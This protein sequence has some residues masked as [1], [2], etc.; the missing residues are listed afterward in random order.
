MKKIFIILSRDPR[1]AQ[2][3]MFLINALLKKNYHIHLFYHRSKISNDAYGEL[4]FKNNN[5]ETHPFDVGSSNK[6]NFIV[7]TLEIIKKF[8]IIKPTHIIAVDKKT[9]FIV[10]FLNFFKKKFNKI[11]MILDFDYPKNESIKES[12]ITKIQFFFS[13]YVD[14]FLFPSTKRAKKFF[15][16]S[17]INDKNFTILSNHFPKNFKPEVS[18][19]LNQI[20][21]DKNIKYSKIVCSLGTIGH[22]H[23]FPELIRSVSQWEDGVILI[24]G[25]WPTK[26]AK[27]SLIKIISEKN[28]QKKVLILSD[29]SEKLWCEILLKS[30]LGICFYKQDSIS[31]QYMAGPSTKLSNYLLANIPFIACDNDDFRT[32][33]LKYNLCE[34][35]NPLEPI[36]ISNKINALINNKEKYNLLK[37]NSRIAFS[38]SL[39]FDV[40]F[41][42]L[43]EKLIILE[44]DY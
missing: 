40:Q 37:K 36:D 35:V 8:N 3:L 4:D 12:L 20:L 10:F 39:N 25:G 29:I 32:F 19:K 30:Y 17:T 28:L 24:I 2:V 6:L 38:E 1:S 43:Y 7:K 31:N 34:L 18:N 44:Q 13:R 33:N 41:Q 23:Y 9:L 16:L 26:N 22:N 42:K 15:Q 11:H 21:N 14:L 5:I 27:E